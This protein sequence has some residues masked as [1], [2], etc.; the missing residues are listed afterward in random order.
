MNTKFAAAVSILAL[1]GSALFESGC[2]SNRSSSGGNP[3]CEGFD[4]AHSDPR[5]IAIAD[6]VMEAL[7]GRAAWDSTRVIE[8]TFA[9]KRKLLWDKATGDFRLDDGARVVLMNLQSGQGRVFEGGEEV[10]RDADKKREALDRAYKIWV[11]DS[12][13]LVMPYKLKDSGVTLNYAGEGKLPD[14]RAC[15]LLKLTFAR[16]GVT[17]ENGYELYVS[18]DKHLVEQW[19]YFKRADDAAPSMTTT[20]ADWQRYGKILLASQ[21]A[22]GPSTDKIAVYDTPPARLT[23]LKD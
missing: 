22:G 16:V 6:Q 7:G 15:D 8:W 5:A 14:G 1:V 10:V 12:Y 13:W 2:A 3:A 9:G 18:K 11:N 20:W 21:H 17:P 4:S 23:Q 19:S